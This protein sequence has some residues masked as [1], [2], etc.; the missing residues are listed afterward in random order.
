MLVFIDSSILCTDFYMKGT[1]FELLKLTDTI[2]LSEI[3]LDEV[4][5]KY[6]EVLC[7]KVDSINKNIS[8]LNQIIA[9]PIALV[10]DIIDKEVNEYNEFIEYF[11]IESGMTIA[12]PYPKC[13]HKAIVERALARKKPFKANGQ[14][15]FRDFLV[16]QTFLSCA[17]SFPDETVCFLTHNKRDFSD[18][19]DDNLLH[20]DL[21]S[22]LEKA[23][24]EKSRIKYWSSFD[25]FIENEIKPRLIKIEK[26]QAFI[27]TLLK[28]NENFTSP[29][30]VFLQTNL[31][32]Q[33]LNDYD[34]FIVG[35]NPE[36]EEVIEIQDFNIEKVLQTSDNEYLLEIQ[37]DSLCNI[38]SFIFKSELATM[39]KKD[40]G[41]SILI[42]PD[43]NEHYACAETEMYIKINIEAIYNTSEK[44]L[45]SYEISNI[46][47]YYCPFCP[48]Y[49]DDEDSD[50]EDI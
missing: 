29:L 31:I 19:K 25:R 42:N 30:E 3:V 20:P 14:D 34:I 15:G 7:L 48:D 37:T 38:K 36:I 13:D 28:D 23:K 35:E 27:S 33:N 12:E 8:E 21:I 50:D 18:E 9:S 43:W 47:D 45:K 11:L 22:D 6:K 2:V 5:N 46:S 10:S 32:G 4:K 17:K 26:N 39:N 24:I 49:D 16:W 44:T 41:D 1:K 40:L